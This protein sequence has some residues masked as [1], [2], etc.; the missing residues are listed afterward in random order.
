MNT[1]TLTGI[2][3]LL[4]HAAV[5]TAQQSP[6]IDTLEGTDS[7]LVMDSMPGKVPTSDTFPIESLQMHDSVIGW[8]DTLEFQDSLAAD[9][10]PGQMVDTAEVDIG[11]IQDK[12]GEALIET[13]PVTA[14]AVSQ[15]SSILKEDPVDK[16]P[17]IADSFPD[18]QTVNSLVTGSS[19]DSLAGRPQLESIDPSRK[20]TQIGEFVSFSKIFWSIVLILINILGLRLI[21]RL[22]HFFADRNAR[23]R[24]MVKAFIAVFRIIAWSIV[25][26]IIIQ[27]IFKPNWQTILA[28]SASI[29]VAVGFAA[30]DFLKN[31]FGGF[32]IIAEK[33]FQV[34]DKIQAG[35]HYGEV[36][37]IGF[38]SSKI[39]TAD[40][41]VVTIPN[42]ELTAEPVS[43]SNIGKTNC[44]V[45]AEFYLPER[46]DFDNVRRIATEAAQISGFVFLNKPI[47]VLFSHE[48]EKE[49]SYIK[50]RLKA[51]VLDVRYEF[52][53]KSQ[54]TEIV[55]QELRKEKII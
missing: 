51:Y 34:G 47:S 54:M 37:S 3:I 16:L 7:S 41:S 29:G 4:L 36:L 55:L 14:P 44:Q 27:V 45:V 50:M 20:I 52:A 38:R 8:T 49:T 33:S 17:A 6:S 32:T 25:V 40:D 53:F 18:K 26:Y 43:N 22:L 19:T 35:E 9:S 15:A 42:A 28:L 11:M 21:F 2:L 23:L 10:P 46:I 5:I 13:V 12:A 39:V 30:Q 1:S 48:R 24:F 31:I